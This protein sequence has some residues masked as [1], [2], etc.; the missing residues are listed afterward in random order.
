MLDLFQRSLFLRVNGIIIAV[1][2]IA[3]LIVQVLLHTSA[4]FRL[5]PNAM[6]KQAEATTELVFL[7]ENVPD[8][9]APLILSTYSGPGRYALIEPEFPSGAKPSKVLSQPFAKAGSTE[10]SI[11]ERETRFRMVRADQLARAIGTQPRFLGIS[12][13]E[14]SVELNDGSILHVFFSPV[15]LLSVSA[16]MILLGLFIVFSLAT[17]GALQVAFRPL[18]RLESATDALGRTAKPHFVDEGGTEDLRRVARAINNM[19]RRIQTLLADRSRMLAALAHDIRT[20][21]THM[22]LRLEADAASRDSGLFSDIV[23]IEQLVGDMLL[24]ARAEQSSSTPELINVNSVL[25]ELVSSLPYTVKLRLAENSFS[26]AAEPTAVRRAILNLLEN[27]NTHAEGVE[28]LTEVNSRGARIVVRDSGPGIPEDALD[29][30]FDPFFRVDPSRSRD[31]GGSGLGLAIARDLLSAQGAT[32]TLANRA[33][34][35]VDAT[36][37][38][39]NDVIVD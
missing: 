17:F 35:G 2:L 20:G 9:V 23:H 28:L 7:L 6:D 8:N 14:V 11:G 36:V 26:I 13:L 38:F 12:V 33:S 4:F 15:V 10:L 30:V 34:G 3:F 25:G 39:S 5:F 31:T 16:P 32:L 24:Y 1:M 19:Q 22:K 21:L 37:S 29:Q 27:A 18:R